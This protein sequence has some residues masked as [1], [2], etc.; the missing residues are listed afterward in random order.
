MKIPSTVVLPLLA[1]RL[2]RNPIRKAPVAECGA[3][4][5]LAWGV[6][7]N[8][9]D[10]R[11][12]ACGHCPHSWLRRGPYSPRTAQESACFRGNPVVSRL[13]MR[14]ESHL[15]HGVSAGQKLFLFLVLT[16]LD[17][18]TGAPQLSRPLVSSLRTGNSSGRAQQ[19]SSNIAGKWPVMGRSCSCTTSSCR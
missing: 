12:V 8:A 3:A 19:P 16:K 7:L 2:A 6:R 4:A 18:F 5:F 11:K 15:G 10:W 14:F 9:Q 17:F 13:G 1:L